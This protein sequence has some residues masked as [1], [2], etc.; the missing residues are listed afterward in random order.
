M[1]L[2]SMKKKKYNFSI[3]NFQTVKKKR[4]FPTRAGDF[5]MQKKKITAGKK[6]KKKGPKKKKTTHNPSE[7]PATKLI[8]FGLISP[9]I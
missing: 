5:L 3:K 9:S 4:L 1:Y 6:K 8:F 2:K 7:A